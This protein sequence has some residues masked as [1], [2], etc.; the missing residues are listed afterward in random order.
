MRWLIRPDFEAVRLGNV[1]TLLV[2]GDSGPSLVSELLAPAGRAGVADAGLFDLRTGARIRTVALALAAYALV[3][4][5]RFVPVGILA[6]L[7]VPL[8]LGD[9]V[10]VLV[11]A[12]TAGAG[13]LVIT[14]LVLTREIGWQWPG[15]SDL[16]LPDAAP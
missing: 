15:P 14:G 5:L 2:L 11:L 12:A 8:A 10:R 4:V 16:V 9:R 7:S 13:S 1:H 3:E 6:V